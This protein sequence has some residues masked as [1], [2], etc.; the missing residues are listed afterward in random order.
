MLAH[1]FRA[2]LDLF[3]PR[4]PPR[5]A[6][7]REVACSLLLLRQHTSES[8]CRVVSRC[9]QLT[10]RIRSRV[11]ICASSSRTASCGRSRTQSLVGC[12]QAASRSALPRHLA[13][14][15]P[16]SHE[17]RGRGSPKVA[18]IVVSTC[19]FRSVA[20]TYSPARARRAY[21]PISRTRRNTRWVA[22]LCVPARFV[23]KR[24]RAPLGGYAHA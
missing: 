10:E 16:C 3:P 15:S 7:S 5:A 22:S 20:S 23:R 21:S 4:E 6:S 2:V 14:S 8:L 17:L 9:L 18:H 11:H 13:A 24:C 1:L 12:E 19:S